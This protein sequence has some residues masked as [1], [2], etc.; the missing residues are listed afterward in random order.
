MR[1][2]LVSVFAIVVWAATAYGQ[3]MRCG[4][5]L[6]NP[7]DSQERVAE[8]CG[9]PTSVRQWV[10]NVVGGDDA[11]PGVQ[12]PMVEWTYVRPGEFSKKITFQGGRVQEIHDAGMP[13]VNGGADD[14]DE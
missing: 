11:G 7:G 9:P 13:A 6:I 12:V 3:P 1:L 4:L 10:S 2:L 8:L 14:D 5:G